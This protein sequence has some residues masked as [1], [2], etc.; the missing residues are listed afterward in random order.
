[1]PRP[2]L[3]MT[4]PHVRLLVLA[5]ALAAGAGFAKTARA[6]DPTGFPHIPVWTFPGAF[7]DS[8]QLAPRG[9]S[10]AALPDSIREQARTITVRFLRNRVAE[11]RPNFGG[12]RIYRVVNT[13]D[14]T[15]M[16][17]I[18]RF[19]RQPGD[20][21]LWHFSIVDANLELRCGT[22]VMNDSVI[23]FVDPDSNGALVKQCRRVDHL[24]R[25]LTPGDS[26]FRLVAPPGPHDGF[27]FLYAVTYEAANEL[28]NNYGEMFVPD[29]LDNYARCGTPGVPN[30]CPNLNNKL[31]NITQVAV[32]P[33]PGP[34]V[35]L[36][37]VAV[38]PNPFR[39]AE[40]WD[41]PNGNEVH[42]INLPAGATIRVYDVSGG[43]VRELKHNDPVRDFER[44]DLKNQS[45][46]EVASGIYIYRVVSS[47]FSFQ[48]RFI[49]IR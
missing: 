3:V 21:P 6:Q 15:R 27:R 44:W 41:Q 39:A 43:L 30:T 2:P 47:A 31:A 20:D 45:G 5:L 26:V 34:T 42:F 35:N 17:L 16:E 1:M 37:T 29:T 46:R 8:T 33:T 19:S 49:V 24:G 4:R 9:C 38:V 23:T 12:Y 7:Q 18:R 13:P 11:S 36:E 22:R 25:C 40:A 28:D 10:R 32:E 48:S 14:T